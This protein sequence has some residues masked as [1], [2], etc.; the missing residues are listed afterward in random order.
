MTHYEDVDQA[1]DG[2]IAV[3][4]RMLPSEDIGGVRVRTFD[5]ADTWK[6][7]D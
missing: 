1:A 3:N 4:A 6:Y 2:R 7:I 5:G